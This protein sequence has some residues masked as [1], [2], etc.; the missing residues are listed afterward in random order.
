M[1]DTKSQIIFIHGMFVTNKCWD[2]WLPYFEDKGYGCF[3]P[4]WPFKDDTPENLRKKH[5]DFEGEGHVHLKDVVARYEK[6]IVSLQNPPIL[7]G[8]SMGALVVQLLLN[9]G[10]GSAGVVIDS[11]PPQ[12][13][14][15]TEFSLFKANWPVLN[16]FINK[17]KPAFWTENQ[18][19][20]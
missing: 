17:Y 11:A 20:F 3:A 19:Q 2:N 16:P 8:H 18:F 10:L 13:V 5:P 12:G 15:S 9:N 14:L 1:P 6:F 4:A 7:I